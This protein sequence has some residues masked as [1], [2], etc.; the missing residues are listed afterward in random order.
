MAHVC[1]VDLRRSLQLPLRNIPLAVLV[2]SGGLIRRNM[3]FLL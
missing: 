3:L 2:M 1:M